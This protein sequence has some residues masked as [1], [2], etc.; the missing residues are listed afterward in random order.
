MPD[1]L[2]AD[3]KPLKQ[4]IKVTDMRNLLMCWRR[5]VI[6]R[7]VAAPVKNWLHVRILRTTQGAVLAVEHE[8]E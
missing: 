1:R 6:F 7:R 2:L 5:E 4:L 3:R 8:G